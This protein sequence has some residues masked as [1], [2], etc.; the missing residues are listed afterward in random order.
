M[1]LVT[2][3]ISK[4]ESPNGICDTAK[5]IEYEWNRAE[6]E[7]PRRNTLSNANIK[8]DPKMAEYVFWKLL[9]YFKAINPTFVSSKFAVF[10]AE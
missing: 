3:Q 5:A 8:C 9:E 1:K 10:L 6:R 4:Q 2:V 7:L